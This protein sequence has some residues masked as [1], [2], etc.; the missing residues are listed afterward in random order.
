MKDP[1]NDSKIGT[2][3]PIALP[4]HDMETVCKNHKWED[5]WTFEWEW[6]ITRRAES[7]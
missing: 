6:A 4:Q 5:L 7:D 2:Y 3:R 1:K